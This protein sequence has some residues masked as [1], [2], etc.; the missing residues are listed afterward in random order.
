MSSE[1]ESGNVMRPDQIAM[2][3]AVD[4]DGAVDVAT[5]LLADPLNYIVGFDTE[6][7]G[8]DIT[9]VSLI[10]FSTMD[11]I[12]MFQ[13]DRIWR[14]KGKLPKKL[15][16]VLES[17]EIVKVGV[18]INLDCRKLNRIYGINV[19]AMVDI[20]PLALTIGIADNS[21]EALIKRYYDSSYSKSS[22]NY[23]GDFDSDLNDSQMEYAAMDA[24]YSLMVY[25]RMM[26]IDIRAAKK[27]TL[28]PNELKGIREWTVY[29]VKQMPSIKK[30]SLVNYLVSGNSTLRKKYP[31]RE[32]RAKALEIVD[33]LIADGKLLEHGAVVKVV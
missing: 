7:S 30:D 5:L 18:G 32:R 21:L 28:E 15:M 25:L 33:G 29:Y 16:K 4:H 13:L 1:T 9:K 10:Q 26:R 24:Y 3:L 31:E 23:R 17:A 11:G 19:D 2:Y 12:Y 8:G 6:T 20:R 22:F 27:V 14:E